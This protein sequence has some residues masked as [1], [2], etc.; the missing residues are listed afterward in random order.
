MDFVFLRAD[1]NLIT[2]NKLRVLCKTGA[3]CL[4]CAVVWDD[5]RLLIWITEHDISPDVF[6]CRCSPQAELP[7]QAEEPGVDWTGMWELDVRL[8]PTC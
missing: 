4:L 6:K 5:V 8:P 1:K 3:L 7:A 2:V